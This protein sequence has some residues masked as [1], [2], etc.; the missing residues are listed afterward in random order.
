MGWA[1]L[2]F[3]RRNNKFMQC[4]TIWLFSLL[5]FAVGCGESENSAP[6]NDAGMAFDSATGGECSTN[7]ECVNSPAAKAL[8]NVRCAGRDIFCL[9]S[10]CHAE[11]T[12]T[13]V[14]ARSDVNP[15]PAPRLCVP[16]LSGSVAFCSITPTSCATVADCSAYL[17]PTADGSE[18]AWACT[19]GLCTYPGFE[20]A[21]D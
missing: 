10:V 19:D 13:C 21:T 7:A 15:C 14:V 4:A 2:P 1:P 8:A 16:N 5:V 9:D 17:P 18:R 3:Q 12:K 20:Y 6:P 11:C